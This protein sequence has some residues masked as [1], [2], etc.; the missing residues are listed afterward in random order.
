[1]RARRLTVVDPAGLARLLQQVIDQRYSGKQLRAAGPNR[2]F[3][4]QLSRLL[5][6]R[7]RSIQMKTFERLMR[8][9]PK[10]LH[11]ELFAAVLSPPV[12]EILGAYSRWQNE[13]ALRFTSRRGRR[14]RMTRRGIKKADGIPFTQRL[15]EGDY[16]LDRLREKLPSYFTSFDKSLEKLGHSAVRK[17]LAYIRI[18][19]PLLEMRESAFVERG[20]QEL[21]DEELAQFINAGMTRERILLRR[22]P[23]L[24]RAQE[25]LSR[26]PR[27][28]S[29][30]DWRKPGAEGDDEWSLVKV[31]AGTPI[32]HLAARARNL[33]HLN[34]LIERENR[35]QLRGDKRSR[36]SARP[37]GQ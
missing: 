25:V 8:L 1:M 33:D 23:D 24:Q 22:S 13:R 2:S 29:E 3:Q 36:K 21:T 27:E 10:G 17:N 35:S 20:W 32:A 37:R 26:P 12:S 9:V 7:Q 4:S 5:A 30:P 11:D 19:E 6:R 14:W 28:L 15:E 34:R 31:F 18:I 16:L